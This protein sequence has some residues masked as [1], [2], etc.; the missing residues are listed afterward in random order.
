MTRMASPAVVNCRCG[1]VV[2]RLEDPS[3]SAVNRVICYCDDC[4]AFAHAL[5]RSDLLDPRGGTDIVQ[6]APARLKFDRG[7]DKIAGIRLAEKGLYRFY[8]QCC[9][10][11]LGNCPGP[12]I[13]FV[14][15]VRQAFET[16]GQDADQ[17][18]GRVAGGVHGETAIGGAPQGSQG[19]PF[20]L[21]LRAVS[22]VL[23]WR[24]ASRGW[25]HPF[26]DSKTRKPAFP[27]TTLSRE[28]R[29]ALSAL[30]GPMPKVTVN[31][32]GSSVAER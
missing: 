22:K 31:G 6:V 19:V 18:F 9:G 23:T 13:P 2:G 32:P 25:P 11:P 24:F 12:G 27:V 21:M 29:E 14:G 10:T 7:Q 3:P 16:S 20:R 1:E 8:A 17:L 15:V 28:C 30:C 26:F 5:G 4:Q